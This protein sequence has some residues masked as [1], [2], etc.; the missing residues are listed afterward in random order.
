M[1]FEGLCLKDEFMSTKFEMPRKVDAVG[2]QP[3][4]DT[5]PSMSSDPGVH[6]EQV[7]IEQR[8]RIN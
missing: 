7:S 1:A 5:P 8:I 4:R 2:M 6:I 3:H